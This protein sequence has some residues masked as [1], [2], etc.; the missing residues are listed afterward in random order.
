MA[1]PDRIALIADIHGNA[2]A[3]AAVLA[4]IR[5][6]GA[7]MI[8]N[9]GDHFSGPL[10]AAETLALIRATPMLCLR[11]NHDRWLI[12]QSPDEMSAS[13]RSA[14]DELDAA[15]LAWLRALPAT[16][17]PCD[18]IF[19]CHATPGDDLTY[20]LQSVAPD[21]RIC[22]RA[23]EDVV[24]LAGARR[25]PLLLCGHT[26]L[27]D[28]RILP[29]GRRILNPGSVGLPAY[30]DD[31]PVPHVMEVGS[32]EARYAILTRNGEGW[33]V[34]WRHVFYDPARMIALAQA[35]GRHDWAGA[36]ATGRMPG[37]A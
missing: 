3:L 6:L 1:Q 5:T 16:M 4:D 22:P 26:H 30:D 19:A 31:V 28:D 34:L 36:L 9:L 14:Y 37:R 11:G 8:C 20:W 13:D 23:A 7:D 24:Q 12:E 15:G 10:A 17:T 29:D 21:G 25:E 2:D 27:P 18:G 35:R 32:P 33:Q